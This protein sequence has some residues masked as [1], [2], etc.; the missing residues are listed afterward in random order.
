[1]TGFDF[2]AELN[3]GQIKEAQAVAIENAIKETGLHK[4][5]STPFFLLFDNDDGV[6]I[7]INPQQFNFKI[8]KKYEKEEIEKQ[9]ETIVKIAEVLT[10]GMAIENC[11]IRLVNVFESENE[12]AYEALKEKTTFDLSCE[13]LADIQT[14]GYRFLMKTDAFYDEF[15]VEP[16]LREP[17]KLFVEGIYNRMNVQPEEAPK[18]IAEAYNN[19][20]EKEK[21]F[22][23]L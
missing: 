5:I 22:I 10:G 21:I 12:K 14:V 1:M 19:Y 11:T 6:Q 17:D 3:L 20:K 7:T 8:A 16:L 4:L 13:Q 23:Q 9:N 18:V 15:K 2:T